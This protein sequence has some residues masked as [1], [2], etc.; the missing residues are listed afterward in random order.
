MNFEE[1]SQA[2]GTSEGANDTNGNPPPVALAS[3]S[4][5]SVLATTAST[6]STGSS[7]HNLGARPKIR[8]AR[9]VIN[10]VTDQVV[11]HQD[12]VQE[13]NDDN[14]DATS[15][16]DFYVYRYTGNG[17]SSHNIGDRVLSFDDDDPLE[18]ADLP[19]SF[20][21]LDV[22]GSDSEA[23][24]LPRSLG[25]VSGA[26][27]SNLSTEVAALI[28]SEMA[29]QSQRRQRLIE[30]RPQAANL[31]QQRPESPDMDFLEMDF[32]PGDEDSEQCSEDESETPELIQRPQ[33]LR[34]EVI[35]EPEVK[36]P[37]ENHA[38]GNVSAPLQSPASVME[39]C[40]SMTRSRSLN[41]PLANGTCHLDASGSAVARH[42]RR[43]SGE[44]GLCTA[45]SSSSAS[46]SAEVNMEL[47]GARLS[48][49]E[50]LV[51]GVPGSTNVHRAML[52]LRMLD[53]I[54]QN[55]D[56]PSV[57]LRTSEDKEQ[58]VRLEKTMIWTE[59]EACKRQVNQIGVSACG[60]T[61]LI[62]VL[63]VI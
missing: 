56:S 25:G 29:S 34:L 30:Q 23:S 8:S 47:C 49:R 36:A 16:D 21:Q 46:M 33:E 58:P 28:Q 51:F 60:A 37:V 1:A 17:L 35:E 4:S 42:K 6:A 22:G 9:N 50:A 44:D 40:S 61:A 55:H 15:D 39:L 11:P 19:K 41:S 13:D 53:I 3:S 26:G 12:H 18:V 27:Q 31:R 54:D 10:V 2:S 45:S 38:A 59:L 57:I 63:Q 43:H 7:T 48:Q 5:S 20:Y 32:D 62:N 52:K 14:E 24:S